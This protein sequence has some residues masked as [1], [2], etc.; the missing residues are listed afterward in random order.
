MTLTFDTR[1]DLIKHLN[2]YGKFAEIGVLNGDF[3]TEIIN[4][5]PYLVEVN[6]IDLWSGIITSGDQN[7]N[8]VLEYDGNILFDHVKNI[9]KDND[10]VKLYK[11]LS[12]EYL[13]NLK[14]NYLNSIYIDADHSYEGCLRDLKLAIRKVKKNGWILG[15]DY[16]FT[17]KCN[18][19]YNF[20]VKKAVDE[21][22]KEYGLNIYALTKDGCMSY[23]IQNIP[24]PTNIAVC[25]LSDRIELYNISWKVIS[26]YCENH[27]YEFYISNKILDT[28]R[29]P[30]WSKILL[31]DEI[32]NRQHDIVVWL[33]DD[34]LITEIQISLEKLL[35]DFIYSDKIIAMSEDTN[36]Q[37]FNCG[38]MAVKNTS[39][40]KDLLKYI[41]NN[42][43][44]N[45][46][47]NFWEQ[48]TM[49][50]L[51]ID[52]QSFKSNIMIYEPGILQ[53]FYSSSIYKDDRYIW[54]NEKTFIC[55]LAGLP[56]VDRVQIMRYLSNKYSKEILNLLL[57][58]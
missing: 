50:K 39:K 27:N 43:I 10:K 11:M 20:G 45:G 58:Y 16:D 22:C 53:G 57:K 19:K 37:I 54:K 36:G 48:S 8:N 40:T 35:V 5:S 15:H 24:K 17:D 56:L 31:I 42:C 47:Q 30:S 3:S 1:Q 9:F 49:Q 7:G 55:H 12:T 33:D 13:S 52:N 26:D 4:L 6:L 28:E 46:F 21:F 23:A 34:M 41:Y 25:S 51:Y 14:D 38:F 32:L 29:H 44:D 18:N 2:L